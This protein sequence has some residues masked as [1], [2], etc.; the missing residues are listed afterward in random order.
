MDCLS[1][2]TNIVDVNN[3]MLVN[4]VKTCTKLNWI[5]I[6][7][8]HTCN[9]EASLAQE[10]IVF[11]QTTMKKGL[12]SRQHLLGPMLLMS[13]IWDGQSEQLL[14]CS[15]M[16][17]WRLVG[18]SIKECYF[19]SYKQTLTVHCIPF[20]A[21]FLVIIDLNYAIFA[22]VYHRGHTLQ[23]LGSM[24]FCLQTLTWGC[25]NWSAVYTHIVQN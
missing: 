20:L 15:F 21:T 12:Q 11:S 14:L 25:S 19:P 4:S 9:C 18:H 7:S 22:W 8:V 3:C 1:T 23:R 16:C 24:S 2:S 17:W 13:W 5:W 6:R 10:S